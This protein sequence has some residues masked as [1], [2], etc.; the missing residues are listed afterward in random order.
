MQGA[1][2]SSRS[3]TREAYE[4]G[5]PFIYGW[6]RTM[7]SAAN[8]CRLL[9]NI[10]NCLLCQDEKICLLF[11]FFYVPP[12]CCA[13]SATLPEFQF[14]RI[15]SG[16]PACRKRCAVITICRSCEECLFFV[17]FY[18][19]MHSAVFQKVYNAWVF[20]LNRNVW[21][22]EIKTESWVHDDSFN[23]TPI[24]SC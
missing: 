7:P 16:T 18:R 9:T 11:H 15:F 22:L 4:T 13:L 24:F 10:W 1:L 6:K 3:V 19:C 2:A 21:F 14:R 12:Y 17:M 8:S 5:T 23:I 20:L